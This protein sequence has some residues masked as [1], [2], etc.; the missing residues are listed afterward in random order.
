MARVWYDVIHLDRDG[1]VRS[2][3]RWHRIDA[4]IR[5]AIFRIQQSAR[6]QKLAKRAE[7]AARKDVCSFDFNRQVYARIGDEIITIEWGG[8]G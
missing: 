7:N 3:R 4:A 2:R 8:A 6:E 5:S 1:Q